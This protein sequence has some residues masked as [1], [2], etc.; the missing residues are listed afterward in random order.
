MVANIF[1]VISD[2]CT[3][4]V[5][6]L[7]STINGMVPIVYDSTGNAPTFV[8]TLLLMAIGFGIVY[9]VFRLIRGLTA[10]LAR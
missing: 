1:Q 10:G 3:S 2:T 7:T 5:S 9:L 6:C 4:F 8:G